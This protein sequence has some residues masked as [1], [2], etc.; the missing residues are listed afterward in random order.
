[1]RLA[2]LLNV[3]TQFSTA[4][5]KT[6]KNLGVRGFIDFLRSTMA[7]PWLDSEKVRP[8]LEAPFQLRL[9]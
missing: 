4:L 2:H 1:M 6:V 7:G 9:D 5:I 8:R 3:L